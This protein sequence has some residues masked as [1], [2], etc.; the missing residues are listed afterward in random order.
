MKKNIYIQ[1]CFHYVLNTMDNR[2]TILKDDLTATTVPSFF[3]ALAFP[4]DAP[5]YTD[6][7]ISTASR[8]NDP[9]S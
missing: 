6:R 2:K 8:N 3:D 4:D 9:D 7:M 5:L 1:R